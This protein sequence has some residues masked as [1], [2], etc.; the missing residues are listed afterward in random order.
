MQFQPGQSGNPAGRPLGARNTKSLAMEEELAKHAQE[1]VDLVMRRARGGDPTCLRLLIERVLPIG[2]NRPLALDLPKVECADDAQ[3]ALTIDAFGRGEITV[4]EFSPMLGSVD[5][6]ARVAERI[7]QN[8]ERERERYGARRVH[9]L[10]PD[11]IPKAPPGWTDPL[12]TVA[13]AIERGEDPFP[14]DLVKSAY[15]LTGERLYSPVN[16]GGEATEEERSETAAEVS[17]FPSPRTECGGEGSGVGGDVRSEQQ[18]ILPAGGADAALTSTASG[19]GMGEADGLYFPVN[20]NPEAPQKAATDQ[21]REAIAYLV[22]EA[23]TETLAPSLPRAAGEGGERSEPG[24][25]LLQALDLEIPER[26][27]RDRLYLSVNS[28]HESAGA[29][30]PPGAADAAPPSPC[31]GGMPLTPG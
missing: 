28:E 24:G 23:A 30:P 19:G 29:S 13:A 1:A 4:R 20:L 15:V 14:D 18:I 26:S 7:Q 11:M 21:E 5:R 31:G 10:H 27:E 12:E 3:V 25:G 2:T 8:R 16:S 9:G 6:M 22:V 17:G